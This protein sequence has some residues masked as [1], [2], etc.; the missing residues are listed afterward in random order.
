MLEW[1]VRICNEYVRM[2]D[3]SAAAFAWNVRPLATPA[4][5]PVASETWTF[6]V[7]GGHGLLSPCLADSE[8]SRSRAQLWITLQTPFFQ[9]YSDSYYIIYFIILIY[10]YMSLYF[11]IGYGSSI[12]S[13]YD[14]KF[15]SHQNLLQAAKHAVADTVEH[16]DTKT[17]R[18]VTMNLTGFNSQGS[19]ASW[20]AAL[21]KHVFTVLKPWC[22]A[23]PVQPIAA[24]SARRSPW[25]VVSDSCQLWLAFPVHKTLEQKAQ[26]AELSWTFLRSTGWGLLPVSCHIMTVTCR[27]IP[28]WPTCTHPKAHLCCNILINILE[29][30]F[31]LF[32]PLHLQGLERLTMTFCHQVKRT[33]AIGHSNHL[34]WHNLAW[35]HL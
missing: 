2:W 20:T 14:P 8:K 4:A 30:S 5:K 22:Q 19:M 6:S 1:H 34:T 28:T 23:A 9:F 15:P 35:N 25:H 21:R 3:A 29:H 17:Q 32:R 27:Q 10:N 16:I 11:P 31:W 13:S 12:C 24:L 26:S 7:G 33:I 18:V